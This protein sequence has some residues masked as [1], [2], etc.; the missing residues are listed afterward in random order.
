MKK[1]TK[2]KKIYVDLSDGT[3]LLEKAAEQ[4]MRRALF[5]WGIDDC[6]HS[7]KVKKWSRSRCAIRI[8]FVSMKMS[9]GMSGWSYQVEFKTWCECV[10][11]D[12]E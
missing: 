2:V 12:E 5:M 10:D 3:R 4:A 8:E 6:G 11:E 9:G 7:T 1:I